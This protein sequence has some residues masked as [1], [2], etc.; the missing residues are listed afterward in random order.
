MTVLQENQLING[1]KIEEKISKVKHN[2]DI[3]SEMKNRDIVDI[4][5][6]KYIITVKRYHLI[7]QLK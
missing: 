7:L 6:P 4:H 5:Q 2:K 3:Y 1:N